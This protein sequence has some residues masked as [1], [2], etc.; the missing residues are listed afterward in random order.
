MT[1]TAKQQLDELM[2]KDRN[3]PPEAQKTFHW[4][5]PDMCH[6]YLSGF[7][8]YQLFINT[9]VDNYL[10]TNK[11][12]KRHDIDQKNSYRSSDRFR[13]MGYEWSFMEFLEN[14][15]YNCDKKVE[16]NKIRISNE[17]RKKEREREEN[18]RKNEK[19]VGATD[20]YAVKITE[21][22]EIINKLYE[23]SFEAAR[24]HDM[25][26]SLEIIEQVD[27]L[28]KQ[29]YDYHR[30]F[31]PQ[32]T[33]FEVC[34]VCASLIGTRDSE[35]KLNDHLEGKQHMGYAK[36]RAELAKLQDLVRRGLIRQNF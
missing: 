10:L 17:Q 18:D 20:S 34:Q 27:D 26:T 19:I 32:G 1:T 25:I 8:P 9:K 6:F 7:C 3:L 12:N 35:D 29:R 5:D 16:K 30:Q 23:E 15:V 13:K 11:C 21:F 22:D 31:G 33:D 28:K 24:N 36:V 14:L 2:G 4:S